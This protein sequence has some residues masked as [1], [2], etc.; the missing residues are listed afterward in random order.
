MRRT[1]PHQPQRALNLVAPPPPHPPHPST[2]SRSLSRA[3]FS[4]FTAFLAAGTLT[5]LICLFDPAARTYYALAAL[6]PAVCGHRGVV[7]GGLSAA[8]IDESCGAVVYCLKAGGMLARGPAFTAALDVAYKST[9]PSGSTLA[10]V[11]RLERV[12]GRK[13]WVTARIMS[14]VVEE[15]GEGKGAEGGGRARPRSTRRGGPCLWCPGRRGRR[16]AEEV[17]AKAPLA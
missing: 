8:L 1:G 12:E 15:G 14:E 4:Q 9:L 6:G 13:A 7:H 10:V 11:A 17:E 3:R 2:C 16:A 5:D